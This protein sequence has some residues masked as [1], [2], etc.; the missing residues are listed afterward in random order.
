[1]SHAIQTDEQGRKRK[2]E[3]EKKNRW[4]TQRKSSHEIT[5]TITYIY[6]RNVIEIGEEK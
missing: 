4:E 5:N 6:D 3:N 1:M 2:E